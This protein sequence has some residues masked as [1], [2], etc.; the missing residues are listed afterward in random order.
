MEPRLVATAGPLK[1]TVIPLGGTETIIGRDPA[2]SISIHDPLVSRRHCLIRERGSEIQL[3]DLDS[4]NGTFVNGEP[5]REKALEHGDR[6]KVGSSQFVFL[7]RD[8]DG[9]SAV[10]LTDSF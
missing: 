3:S 7:L 1:G 5:L 6:I 10:P 4:L 8:E 9:Q 2:N